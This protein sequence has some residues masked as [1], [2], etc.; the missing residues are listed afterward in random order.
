MFQSELTFDDLDTP[1]D[2]V[3]GGIFFGRSSIFPVRHRLLRTIVLESDERVAIISYERF[4]DEPSGVHVEVELSDSALQTELDAFERHLLDFAVLTVDRRNRAVRYR[5]SPVISVPVY[6]I[7]DGDGVS[8]DWDYARLLDGRT[9]EIVWD[10]ALAQIAGVPTYG[11]ATVVA[12]VH[13]ATAGATLTVTAQGVEVE[14]PEA[15][16]HDGP[17]EILPETDIQARLFETVKSL[18]EV[19]P[20]DRS[21]TALELS[22]GMDSGLVSMAAAAV[23]GPGLMSIGAQF[24]GTM[25]EAQRARRRLL[26]DRGGFDDLSVPAE[27]FAPFSPTSLRRVRYGVW[28][29]DE[30][31]PEIF[32]AI[33]GMLRA[34]G[35]D[36][37]VSGFGGDE[38]YLTYE[39][40][41]GGVAGG[42]ATP[43]PFLTAKGLELAGA[44]GLSYPRAWLQETCWQSAASQSQRLLRYGLWPIYPYHNIAL[45][46]FISRLPRSYRR[47][48]Q[49]L[50]KTL[51]RVLGEPVF[52]TDY[53]KERFDPVARRGIS[54]NRDYLI[55]LVRRSSLSRHPEIRDEAIL[56][57]LAGDIGVLD[58]DSFNALF[59]VLK[60]FCFFQ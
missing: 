43:C 36:A 17:H 16:T 31:Y 27:R 60:V 55:D 22:G 12:G 20:L 25:G 42:G 11:P 13:R 19:R 34:A 10:I 7:A 40:E 49:L 54:E 5:A 46:R 35:I 29:E 47:D 44:A 21:R 37:L 8:I 32:E 15:I 30:N 41:D 56:A 33:F 51:T 26:R 53:V 45:A 52:E 1:T 58:H 3:D 39:G 14:L 24:D 38:L 9:A 6:L 50:R 28:P 59:R 48:R 23:T 57:A 4:S 2:V 18:I